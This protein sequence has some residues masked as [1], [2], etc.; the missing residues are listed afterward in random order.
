VSDVWQ[1]YQCGIRVFDSS[2]GGLGGCPFAP[3]AKVNVATE[4]LVYLF[5]RAAVHTGVDLMKLV[6]VG[7]WISQQL[8]K[9]NSSRAGAALAVKHGLVS[10]KPKSAALRRLQWK[11]VSG[12]GDLRVL[13]SGANLK[14]VLNRP[15]NGNALTTATISQLVQT[16]Q[17]AIDDRT[18]SR[19]AIVGEGKFFCTGMDL[20]KG[21]SP[22]AQSKQDRDAQYDR[23][24]HLFE[25]IDKR[26]LRRM[27]FAT[28]PRLGRSKAANAEA[29]LRR[30]VLCWP[31]HCGV[32]Y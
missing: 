1:A 4:D 29:G 31:H 19:I 10:S 32:D 14:V 22:V 8:R 6:E 18:I 27:L 15:R 24:T 5:D 11:A 23:L 7:A 28:N 21:S 20:G 2:V 26:Q 9:G 17:R 16:F 30:K 3:G 25:V 12:D 13:R